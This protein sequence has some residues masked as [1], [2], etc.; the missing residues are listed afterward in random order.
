M[1]KWMEARFT[2]IRLSMFGDSIDS[3]HAACPPPPRSGPA[4]E[5]ILPYQTGGRE[6][7]TRF[8]GVNLDI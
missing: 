2:P 1:F 4:T 7:R 5:P 6:Q 8:N 3:T